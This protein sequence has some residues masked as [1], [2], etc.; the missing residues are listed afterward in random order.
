MYIIYTGGRGEL[1][2]TKLTQGRA[3]SFGWRVNR[4]GMDAHKG[5]KLYTTIQDAQ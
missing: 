5:G 4:G 1:S 2:K 3:L